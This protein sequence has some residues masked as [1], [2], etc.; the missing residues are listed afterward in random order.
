[1]LDAS[2]VVLF[3]SSS[4]AVVVM[5]GPALM[6]I[7][8]VSASRGYSAGAM[9]CLGLAIGVLFHIAGAALGISVIF[10]QSPYAFHGLKLLGAAYLITIGVLSLRQTSSSSSSQKNVKSTSVLRNV[11]QA[12]LVNLLNP[13]LALFFIAFIPQFTDPAVGNVFVQ[14]VIMGMVFVLIATSFNLFVAFVTAKGSGFWKGQ[15]SLPM[16]RWLP[17]FVFIGLGVLLLFQSP[18]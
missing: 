11:L 17:S 4:V 5:P 2:T 3:I 15:S 9:A 10:N 1:M 18:R 16:V 13:K 14:T 8:T 6:Y 7:A 12:V